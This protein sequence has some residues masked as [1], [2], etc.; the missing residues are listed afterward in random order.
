VIDARRRRVRGLV[1]LTGSEPAF[2]TSTAY[3][4]HARFGD[5]KDVA[6]GYRVSPFATL[7]PLANRLGKRFRQKVK[8][9]Q[10]QRIREITKADYAAVTL[11]RQVIKEQIADL[12]TQLAAVERELGRPVLNSYKLKRLINSAMI[13]LA[14]MKSFCP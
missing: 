4:T 13:T 1:I 10:A 5:F 6:H 11:L 7:G 14:E 3:T 9:R 2:S 8:R 12:E